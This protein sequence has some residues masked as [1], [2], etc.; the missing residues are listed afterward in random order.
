[1]VTNVSAA[2]ETA[3]VAHETLIR[4]WPRLVEWVNRDRAFHSWLRQIDSNIELWAAHRGDD[5]TLLRGGMLA[6]ASSGSRSGARIL[7]KKSM[8]FIEASVE[9]RRR[10]EAEREATRQAEIKRQQELADAAIQLANEQRQRA[11]AALRTERGLD[12][13][14]RGWGAIFVQDLQPDIA[15]HLQKL[16]DHRR[17]A[18][19]SRYLSRRPTRG[20]SST[21]VGALRSGVQRIGSHPVLS[22]HRWKSAANSVLRPIR[23]RQ[24][25]RGWSNFF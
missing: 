11:T 1:M 20:D 7:A 16:L 13:A 10:E 17:N 6:Q 5:G 23:T 12:L 14:Q 24:Q 19:G 22:A 3:E 25:S 9:L 4:H 18:A 15:V 2:R 21:A 8:T